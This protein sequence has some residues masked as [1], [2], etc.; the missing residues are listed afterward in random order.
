MAGESKNEPPVQAL[1]IALA[2]EVLG[3]GGYLRGLIDRG[4]VQVTQYS[5]R[6]KRFIPVDEIERLANTLG[7][8]PDWEKIL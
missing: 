4:K 8:T 3:L 5:P 7:I 1:P 6:S 2:E